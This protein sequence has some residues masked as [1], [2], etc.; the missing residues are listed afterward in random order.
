MCSVQAAARILN[1]NKCFQDQAAVGTAALQQPA[2]QL[3][4][5]QR[6]LS[7]AQHSRDAAQVGDSLLFAFYIVPE[8]L[9]QPCSCG[10]NPF[11][12]PVCK[13]LVIL[14]W[15]LYTMNQLL[16]LGNVSCYYTS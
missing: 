8:L 7:L 16:V 14:L 4:Q 6:E 1:Y 11:G 15:Q 13:S 5:L 10:H 9:V 12:L 3:H 2:S